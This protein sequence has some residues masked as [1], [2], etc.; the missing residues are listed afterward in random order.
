M[1]W[2]ERSGPRVVCIKIDVAPD[3][4]GTLIVLSPWGT[5]V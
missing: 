3:A 2:A 4:K 1:E 5:K